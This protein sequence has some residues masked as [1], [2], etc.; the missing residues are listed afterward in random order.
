MPHVDQRQVQA[1]HRE[2]VLSE[3]TRRRPVQCARPAPDD[4]DDHDRRSR[5]GH[6]P[7]R[8][9]PGAGDPD[10]FIRQGLKA[11]KTVAPAEK[12]Y[13]QHCSKPHGAAPY[14]ATDHL[15]LPAQQRKADADEKQQLPA[16]RIEQTHPHPTGQEQCTHQSCCA[17]LSG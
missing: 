5:E 15:A 14:P 2:R 3:K 1:E 4:L 7:Q 17:E 12:R 9:E 6:H 8:A 10:G 11:E 16:Q 13:R